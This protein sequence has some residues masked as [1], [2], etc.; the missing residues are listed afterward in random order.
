M[1][2]TEE[3]LKQLIKEEINKLN[4]QNAVSKVA[5]INAGDITG[6]VLNKKQTAQALG[7]SLEILRDAIVELNQRIIKLEQ[8]K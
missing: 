2:I 4:E 7:A 1:K 5:G 8:N 6:G 3:K